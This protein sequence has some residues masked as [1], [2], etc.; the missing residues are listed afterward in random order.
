MILKLKLMAILISRW[1]TVILYIIYNFF[2]SDD[3][4]A[5]FSILCYDLDDCSIR[6]KAKDLS[7]YIY[8][9]LCRP[10]AK[11]SDVMSAVLTFES[12]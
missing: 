8:T 1:L 6:R 3:S 7:S 4:V 2:C 11:S 9:K 5:W 12:G 10:R